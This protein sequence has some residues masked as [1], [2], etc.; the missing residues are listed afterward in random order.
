MNGH[1]AQFF[2]RHEFSPEELNMLESMSLSQNK[3]LYY[4]KGMRSTRRSNRGA[5]KVVQ[6]FE[7]QLRETK[8]GRMG[9]YDD[10][11][12]DVGRMHR[13]SRAVTPAVTIPEED[14]SEEGKRQE[15]EE[16]G[17]TS[18]ETFITESQSAVK[19]AHDTETIDC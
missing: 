11:S 9:E 7:S 6:R 1:S 4:G 2:N 19:I 8:E 10:F 5:S 3:D 18:K 17:R 15:R 12:I 14:T 16:Q 13:V